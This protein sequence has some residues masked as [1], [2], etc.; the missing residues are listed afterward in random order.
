MCNAM[1]AAA[2]G[3]D[4][5]FFSQIARGLGRA[6]RERIIEMSS[7]GVKRG[8]QLSNNSPSSQ[9]P[10]WDAARRE[11]FLGTHLIKRFRVPAVNQVLIVT[12]FQEL[13]WPVCIDDPLPPTL[14]IDPKQ[15]MQATIRSLNG[16][17]IHKAIR[18]HGNGTGKQVYWKLI[19]R[20]S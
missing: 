17:Q 10:R 11:L 18:F 20:P 12:A 19:D 5:G 7:A 16:R 3:I 13:D 8:P 14:E 4:S 2:K 15:R 9:S 1:R 6:L